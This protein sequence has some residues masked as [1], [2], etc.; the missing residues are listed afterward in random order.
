[1]TPPPDHLRDALADGVASRAVEA[2]IYSVLST[3]T[4]PH[5]YDS[6]AALYDVVVGSRP[7]NRLVWGCSPREYGRF[8]ERAVRSAGGCFLEAGCGSLVFTADVYARAERPLIVMDQSLGM[9]R[10]A[11]ERLVGR[12][13]RVPAHVVL[14]QADL[15]ALPFRPAAF[16]TIL[17]L[18]V[19]HLVPDAAAMLPPLARCLA[20]GGGF[21]ATSLVRSGGRGD[22]AMALYHRMGEL[23]PP[24]TPAELA[25]AMA[26][27]LGVDP[28]V[29]VAGSMAFAE[30][31]I[32]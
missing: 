26:Q 6:W 14:L 19:L 4:G 30:C 16:R 29:R 32:P 24:R 27:A 25:E 18:N 8:A 11:R 22:R 2:G 28:S 3:D 23:A 12:A 10:R 9:L 31:T 5:H 17:S 7:Y 15:G 20:P 21:F 13:G 1:M